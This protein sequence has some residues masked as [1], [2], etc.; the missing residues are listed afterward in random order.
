[1]LL[2]DPPVVVLDEA[3]ADLPRS[4][5]TALDAALDGVLAGR[6]ALLVAHRLDQAVRADR[7][8]V[9]AEGRVVQD[10]PP[11]AL[12]DVEGPF[13]T[14]WTAWIGERTTAADPA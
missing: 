14:L 5:Q 9:M 8:V 11:Q 7:I 3:T 4:R 6:T 13:R 10:G 12:I 1:V 2:A